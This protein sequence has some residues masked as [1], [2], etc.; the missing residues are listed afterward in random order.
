MRIQILEG[1]LL[2][3]NADAIVNSW[4]RNIIPWWLLVPHGVSGAIKRRAGIKPFRELARL[5]SIPPGGA[6]P[7]SAGRL[8]FKAI[9]HV[10]GISLLGRSSEQSIRNCVR[11]A[12]ALAEQMKLSSLAFPLIGAGCGGMNALDS[13]RIILDELKQIQSDIFATIVHPGQKHSG[14]ISVK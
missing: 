12:I 5:G 13:E 1:D 3:Q 7:T 2:A 6:V 9:I 11:N 4:N 14:A 8:P 10:A